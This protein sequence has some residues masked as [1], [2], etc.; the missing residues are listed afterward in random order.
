METTAIRLIAEDTADR[1]SRRLKAIEGQ[2]RGL[3]KMVRE[4]RPCV[5]ILTQTAAA[6]EA[7]S[8]VGR[9][10]MRNY[11]EGCVTRAIQSGEPGDI[12]DEL[13]DVIYKFRR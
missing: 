3:H 1:L 7:L 9:L 2:V 5:E 6:Q 11:L 8:Q 4:D 12:Y 13:L 10:V